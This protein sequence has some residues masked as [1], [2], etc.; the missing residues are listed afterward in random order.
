LNLSHYAGDDE[1]STLLPTTLTS[2]NDAWTSVHG[3]N[4]TQSFT[5]RYIVTTTE[6]IF[7]TEAATTTPEGYTTALGKKLDLLNQ[8]NW[9][10]GLDKLQMQ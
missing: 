3:V 1:P 6:N 10:I 2:P 4:S 5:T 7:T 8:V 9:K